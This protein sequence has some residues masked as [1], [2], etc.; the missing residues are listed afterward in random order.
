MFK[1]FVINKIFK[2]NFLGACDPGYSPR[3]NICYYIQLLQPQQPQTL[4]QP[5]PSGV[6]PRRIK[7]FIIIF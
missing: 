2:I 5:F 4:Q 3:N 1:E 6:V 7:N